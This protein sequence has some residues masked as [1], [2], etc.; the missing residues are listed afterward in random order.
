M[1]VPEQSPDNVIHGSKVVGIAGFIYDFT[2]VEK[3]GFAIDRSKGENVSSIAVLPDYRG[4]GFVYQ[5]LSQMIKDYGI[6]NDLVLKMEKN[7]PLYEKLLNFYQGKGFEIFSGGFDH[8]FL[9]RRK[10]E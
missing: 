10:S 3:R 4:Q 8:I 1:K 7:Q 5:M 2:N 6:E 9:R